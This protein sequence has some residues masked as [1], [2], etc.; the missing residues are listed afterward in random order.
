MHPLAQNHFFW[1]LTVFGV[2]HIFFG[3]FEWTSNWEKYQKQDFSDPVND[4]GSWGSQ[5]SNLEPC[6]AAIVA[7]PSMTGLGAYPPNSQVK[8]ASELVPSCKNRSNT[9]IFDDFDD[10]DGVFCTFCTALPLDEYRKKDGFFN[11]FRNSRGPMRRRRSHWSRRLAR[12]VRSFAAPSTESTGGD[13]DQ[14]T[15]WLFN[16]AMENPHF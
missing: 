16:I 5:H 13:P 3:E 9:C 12:S 10:F 7:Q 14:F 6:P 11:E 4:Y 8:S 15:L 2:T 1:F